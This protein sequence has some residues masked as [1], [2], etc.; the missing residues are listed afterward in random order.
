MNVMRLRRGQIF[1]AIVLLYLFVRLM[2]D[3][4]S[5]RWAAGLLGVLVIGG[6]AVAPWVRGNLRL[7]LL[8]GGLYGCSAVYWL[9]FGQDTALLMILQ[10]FL[11]SYTALLMV[12]PASALLAIAIFVTTFVLRIAYD[13]G[14]WDSLLRQD[15][16]MYAGMY[17]LLRT[18]RINRAKRLEEQRHTEELRIVHAELAETHASL[19]RAHEELER[20]TMQSLRYAVLEER[21]RIARDIHDSIGHRLTSVIVQLQALPYVLKSDP[22]E[23]EQIV[24]TVLD[25]AR[26]CLQEVRVVV[27][28]M[29]ADGSGAGLISLRSLVQQTASTPGVPQIALDME[30]QAGHEEWPPGVAAALYRCLQEA[31]TNTI[32]HAGAQR[33][34]IRVRQSES[35]V[36]L[37]YRD[38]GVLT[39]GEPII[40]GFGLG[41]IRKRCLDAGGSCEIAAREPH[42]IAIDI[43]LPLTDSKK[44]APYEQ[45]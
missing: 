28:N 41:G 23:S 38:D 26:S 13:E 15:L 10:G 18:F 20:A 14:T 45:G 9:L 33:I 30:E 39:P 22:A 24:R 6:L 44:E 17:A 31:L 12:E 4:T 40:E 19:Q 42:G 27:H 7:G 37:I 29:E 3:T 32:R 11:I 43:A 8:L 2:P 21:G 36:S 1:S 25:V 35:E 34:E 16:F 5:E